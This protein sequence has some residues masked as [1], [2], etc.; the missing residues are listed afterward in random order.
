MTKS[1]GFTLIEVAIV[2][3]VLTL[4]LGGLLVPLS[5]QIEQRRYSEAN[6]QIEE[7]KEAIIGFALTNGRLPCPGDAN[8]IEIAVASCD[9]EYVGE[10]P[11]ATLNVPMRDPWGRRFVYG[12]S[13]NLIAAPIPD[14]LATVANLTVNGE[15]NTSLAANIAAVVLSRGKNGL[16][17][18]GVAAPSATTDEG[19]NNDRDTTFVSRART[20]GVAGCSDSSATAASC[21]FDD[22]VIWISPF[23]LFNRMAEVGH[24]TSN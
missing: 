12:V 21:E 9:G 16:G 3:L 7:I 19:E 14:G 22:A 13:S 24:F 18:V 15:K 11:S 23:V 5:K 6:K 10:L 8:G 17:A 1:Y 2:T 4:L 20:D